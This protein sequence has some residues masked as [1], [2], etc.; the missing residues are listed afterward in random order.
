L[1]QV[2]PPTSH[3]TCLCTD[4]VGKMPNTPHWALSGTQQ[5]SPVENLTVLLQGFRFFHL[6]SF[7]VIQVQ[8]SIISTQ[9]RKVCQWLVLI[10]SGKRS[11]FQTWHPTTEHWVE[12]HLKLHV[13]FAEHWKPFCM[14]SCRTLQGEKGVEEDKRNMCRTELNRGYLA[15]CIKLFVNSLMGGVWVSQLFIFW[16][17]GPEW[18]KD[19]KSRVLTRNCYDLAIC[20]VG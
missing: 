15:S 17:F 8:K 14:V 1:N 3:C 12:E 10:L 2:P 4:Q 13:L 20:I 6:L 7:A 18:I 9:C 16:L 19:L 5:C 11:E